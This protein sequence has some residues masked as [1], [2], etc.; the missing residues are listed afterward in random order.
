[1]SALFYVQDSRGCV[2]N[3][4]LWWRAG[5]KG[6][7]TDLSE[8]GLYP[9]AEAQSMHNNRTTDIPWPKDYVEARTRP[10]V[11]VQF[12]N[13]E[14][15]HAETGITLAV[16]AKLTEYPR[17]QCQ[18]CGCFLSRARSHCAKCGADRRP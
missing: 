4:V 10:A 11:D 13:R 1:M 16:P 7:T 3:D 12:L 8:A 9:K 14:L 17:L 15:A 6:Y 18:Q 5:G 2:G